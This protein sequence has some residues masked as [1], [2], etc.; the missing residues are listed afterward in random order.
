MDHPL[1]HRQIFMFVKLHVLNL[2]LRE[3]MRTVFL[4]GWLQDKE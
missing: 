3:S 4:S 1:L 2:L